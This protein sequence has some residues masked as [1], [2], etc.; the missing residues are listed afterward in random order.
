M[1]PPHGGLVILLLS[2][3]LPINTDSLRV[4]IGHQNS[5]AKDAR[6]KDAH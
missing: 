1:C 4:S 2:V 5:A 6:E 3:K